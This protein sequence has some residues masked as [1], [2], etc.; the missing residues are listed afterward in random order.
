MTELK[1]GLFAVAFLTAIRGLKGFVFFH[2]KDH[3]E[4]IHDEL[5]AMLAERNAIVV[6]I[7]NS[8]VHVNG[9][10]A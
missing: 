6:E 7:D 1:K 9:G 4:A 2:V 3:L 8:R 10:P 5:W